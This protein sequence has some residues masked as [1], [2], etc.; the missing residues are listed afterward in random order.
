M[1]TIFLLC[2][3]Y[4]YKTFTDRKRLLAFA[5][6]YFLT[7]FISAACLFKERI[8]LDGSYY[9]FHVVNAESFRVE[10]QRYILIA[11]QFLAWLG[12]IF[13]LP[14][15]SIVFLNSINPVLYLATL[16]CLSFY[17]LR[18][19]GACW[20]L[21]LMGVCGMYFL[22]FC[23]MY[24]V[25]YGGMLLI[26]FSA[27]L[28]KK[29]YQTISQKL[30]FNFMLITV[31]FAYPLLVIGVVFVLLFHISEEKKLNSSLSIQ[32]GFIFLFWILYKYFFISDYENGKIS[33]PASQLGNILT[34][35]LGSLNN[36]YSLIKFLVLYYGELLTMAFI[37]VYHM[38]KRKKNRLAVLTVSVIAG[39]IL[40]I[41]TTQPG[42]WI[43]TNYFERMYLTL[44][45]LCLMPFV[46]EVFYTSSKKIIWQIIFVLII[47]YR[48]AAILQHADFYSQRNAQLQQLIA[49]AQLNKG[50][51]F[52]IDDAKHPENDRLYEWSLP[53]ETILFSSLY[54]KDHTISISTLS[55]LNQKE[56]MQKLN[57]NS[58][59]L[60]LNE[61]Y[62][63]GWL[64]QRYFHL[65]PGNYS[66][67]NDKL[68]TPY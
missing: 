33:W 30:F 28:D 65:H 62:D 31:L 8:F 23:P 29:R 50:S 27:L 5:A 13:S 16:F 4:F 38:V 39:Y 44:V 52:Y 36:I 2:K 54:N 19:E 63:D 37:A 32:L 67:I 35:N 57:N 53:M 45:P 64:N 12:T 9:F 55:E 22:Y 18:H 10:H 14:L 17:W 56:V 68:I 48:G 40:L 1:L 7:Y 58:F 60:R 21:L 15:N 25:W 6:F 3:K 34:N 61:V 41:N 11:S 26:F 43:R 59:H 24:E 49:A 47:I 46:K 51:K 66:E 20:A 42:P